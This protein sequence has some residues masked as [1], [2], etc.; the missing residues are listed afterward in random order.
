MHNVTTN[1]A[2]FNM[3]QNQTFHMVG[4][5]VTGGANHPMNKQ[6]IQS[7][8]SIKLRG[9]GGARSNN[10]TSYNEG[11]TIKQK[12]FS[13]PKDVNGMTSIQRPNDPMMSDAFA[14]HHHH[15]PSN[16]TLGPLVLS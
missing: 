14:D 6:M 16:N 5:A 12:V 4:D 2:M 13:L 7:G 1:S 9:I 3:S 15:G 8:S 10:T 11:Q